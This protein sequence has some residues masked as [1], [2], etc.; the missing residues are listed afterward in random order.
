MTFGLILASVGAMLAWWRGS[1]AFGFSEPKIILIAVG[2]IIAGHFASTKKTDEELKRLVILYGSCLVLPLAF[3][4]DISMS[5]VGYPGVFVGSILTFSLCAA[6][7]LLAS[8]AG[9]AGA[10]RIRKAIMCAGTIV[11]AYSMLQ[12]FDADPF[13]LGFADGHRVVGTLGS[14]IDLGALMVVLMSFNMSPLWMFGIFASGSKG[15]WLGAAVAALP[16]KFRMAGFI[17]A[18]VA[19]ISFAMISTRPGDID[20]VKIW[21]MSI[22]DISV[23]TALVGTGPATTAIKS[24]KYQPLGP[25]QVQAHAHNSIL[26][27]FSSCGLIGLIGLLCV[28]AFP[29]LAGLWTISMFDPISFEVVF[30]ACVLLGL[31][32]NKKPTIRLDS[33]TKWL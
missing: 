9:V 10:D 15:A 1:V 19:G 26:E 22:R 14:P 11:V 20:R 4:R 32:R 3:G 33:G 18:S 5:M 21:R 16:V 28:A 29:V 24:F 13:R 6:G 30:V 31:S 23:K 2:V 8:R 25:G 17:V 27:T 7:L 12:H